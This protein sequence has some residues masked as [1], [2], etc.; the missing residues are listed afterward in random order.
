MDTQ[1][2]PKPKQMMMNKPLSER[3]IGVL[4][5][6]GLLSAVPAYFLIVLAFWWDIA[7]VSQLTGKPVAVVVYTEIR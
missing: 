2:E 3:G 6:V 5:L 4:A 7:H 1:T